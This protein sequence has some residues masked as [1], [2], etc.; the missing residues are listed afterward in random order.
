M[1]SVQCT[2]YAVHCTLYTHF[3]NPNTASCEVKKKS[4]AIQRGTI[5]L[6]IRLISVDSFIRIEVSVVFS[7]RLI[8][9][10]IQ[11][12]NDSLFGL[13]LVPIL[14]FWVVLVYTLVYLY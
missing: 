5:I 4:N 3:F 6:V 10:Y 12:D 1:Y 7:T 8:D 14:S 2:L 11:T 13:V 9:V